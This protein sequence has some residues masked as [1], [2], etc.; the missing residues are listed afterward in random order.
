MIAKITKGNSFKGVVS[1]ILD[2]E[3][4]AKILVCDGLFADNKDTI[5]MI[6]EAQSK[7]NPRVTKPVGHISL[8]FHKEDEHRLTDRAMAGIALEYLKGMGIT[9]TQMLIVRHFDKEHPHVHISFNRIACDG[10]TI[11]DR[12]E[13]IRSACICKE[14]TRMYDLYFASGK[15]QVKRHSLKEPDKTKYELHSILN[16]SSA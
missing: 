9:D 16:V 10:R 6:F 14:L 4:D 12:N 11:S 3:K 13:R 7:M 1:Y 15:E 8:A 5:A 2:K